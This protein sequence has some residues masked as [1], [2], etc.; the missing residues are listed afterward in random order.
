MNKPLRFF[1]LLLTFVLVLAACSGTPTPEPTPEPEQPIEEEVPTEEQPG[2]DE[3]D[4]DAL[5]IDEEPVTNY[6]GEDDT[7]YWVVAHPGGW[8]ELLEA[9]SITDGALTLNPITDPPDHLLIPWLDALPAGVTAADIEYPTEEDETAAVDAKLLVIHG[10]VVGEDHDYYL[11]FESKGELGTSS[12]TPSP[13]IRN[14][15]VF[16]TDPITASTGPGSSHYQ[17]ELQLAPG[18]I[19]TA[20]DPVCWTASEVS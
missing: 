6:E 10:L 4:P 18:R 3:F 2:E 13:P 5:I 19:T 12:I 9:G 11:T 15:F 8:E 7:V 14:G 16:A 17:L 20:V 1:A